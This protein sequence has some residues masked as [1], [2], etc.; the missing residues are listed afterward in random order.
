MPPDAVA[1]SHL[2]WQADALW[3]QLSPYLPGLSVEV[4]ARAESTNSLLLERARV[5]GGR[6][7]A[8]VSTPG[9]LEAIR[10]RGQTTGGGPSGGPYGRRTGD[11]QPCLLVAEHQTIGRG[12]NGRAW[13]AAPGASLTFSI[14]LPLAPRDWC[15]LSLAVGV[16][17]ADALDPPEPGRAAPRIA[18]KWPN[19]L[20]LYEGPGR[21]R[22]LGGVLIETV[23]VG[24]HRMAVVG[25]GLNV[26]ALPGRPAS[27][28]SGDSSDLT[29][30]FASLHEIDA[31]ASAPAVLHRV[32]LPLVRAV[33]QF[34][35]EGFA[36]FARG[37]APRDL[38]RGQAVRV[39]G[40]RGDVLVEGVADT[41]AAN[42]ALRVRDAAGALH[43]V[44]S[45]EVSVRLPGP[46][47]GCG[48][49]CAGTSGGSLM[50]LLRWFV[51]L[52]L[53]AN[54]G[55]AAWNAGALARV[56][57]VPASERDPGRL[58]QQIRPT[59]LRVLTPQAA[60]AAV[61][62]PASAPVVGPPLP[63]PAAAPAS[64]VESMAGASAPLACLEIGPL[65]NAAAVDAAERTLATVLPDR[66]WAREQRPAGAQYVVFVG[67]VLS[68]EAARQ[69]RDELVKL[70]MS[71]EAVELPGGASSEK[72]GGYSLGKHD[73]ETAA[74]AALDALRER[75]LRNAR[76]ALLRE[77]GSPRTWL[78]L[79]N[80]R[81]AAA[82]AV[83]LL[84]ADK[85]GGQAAA[86]C[87]LGSAMS[88]TQPR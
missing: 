60:A 46:A 3:Q 36:G 67:P 47:R 57:L 6:H 4:L 10:R 32:A 79:D 20:W 63:A 40:P 62:T 22:K 1:S 71:F 37:Y 85:L 82:D 78:R 34:E 39:L 11:T 29:H 28:D 50:S 31:Q 43:D 61:V 77:S 19:D 52:A 14:G 54:V 41:I 17:L 38:M 84:P 51:A 86:M 45:G 44:S 35:R 23:A 66:P 70:K 27:G 76:V 30:G 68:R 55:Y 49:A 74:Q 53:L 42:G 12:R 26:Q 33:L 7:D 64:A 18:L 69:R 25:V 9:E 16:A 15:G 75:G 59:A 81:D 21:G 80:V 5:G 65:D 88:T 24:T 8:P 56:G 13:H 58:E 83:R 73:S 72:Q 87:V 2:H 48:S